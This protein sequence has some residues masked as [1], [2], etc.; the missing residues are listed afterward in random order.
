MSQWYQPC[1][2]WKHEGNLV[3]QELK[4]LVGKV[5]VRLHRARWIW[6]METY[7]ILQYKIYIYLYYKDIIILDMNRSFHILVTQYKIKIEMQIGGF[8]SHTVNNNKFF[9]LLNIWTCYSTKDLRVPNF[10]AS[11][12]ENVH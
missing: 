9:L 7:T 12:F 8:Y 3:A 5:H 1:H 4:K 6:K 10:Y 2:K 11:S